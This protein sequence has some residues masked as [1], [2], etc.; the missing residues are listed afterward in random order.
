MF[1]YSPNLNSQHYLTHYYLAGQDNHHSDNA[2]SD[3]HASTQDRQVNILLF[4]KFN[5]KK[6]KK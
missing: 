4:Y 1:K 5:G 2:E 3:Y 6:N